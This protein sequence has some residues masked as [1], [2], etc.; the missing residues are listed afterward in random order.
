MTKPMFSVPWKCF[1]R[2]AATPRFSVYWL[3]CLFLVC[4]ALEAIGAYYGSYNPWNPRPGSPAYYRNESNRHTQTPEAKPWD[5]DAVL[6]NPPPVYPVQPGGMTVEELFD[7]DAYMAEPPLPKPDAQPFDIDAAL[8]AY[9]SDRRDWKDVEQLK[10]NAFRRMW[11]ACPPQRPSEYLCP[12]DEEVTYRRA[13]EDRLDRLSIEQLR[14]LMGS[15]RRLLAAYG[16]GQ[17]FEE[18]LRWILDVHE[19]Q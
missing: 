18:E 3:M 5:L 15:F 13:W 17:Q 12:S 19:S 16:P 1:H 11:E 8:E 6:E 9:G 10:E 2:W 14:Q 4:L 7:I